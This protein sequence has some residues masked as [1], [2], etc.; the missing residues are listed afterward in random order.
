MGAT[1]SGQ[2]D[3]KCEEDEEQYPGEDEALEDSEEDKLL[4]NNGQ[5]SSQSE[6][7]ENLTDEM[8]SQ[9]EGRD[10]LD[11]GSG[12]V[13]L[14]EDPSDTTN[15]SQEDVSQSSTNNI[16]EQMNNTDDMIAKEENE[17]NNKQND[18]EI[19][20]KKI[21]RF[22]GL[23]FTLKKDK[24]EK[25]DADEPI[26]IEEDINAASPSEDSWDTI[27]VNAASKTEQNTEVIMNE[28]MGGD[29]HAESPKT[30]NKSAIG[31]ISS[32]I[33]HQEEAS[34]DKKNMEDVPKSPE[35]EELMSPIKRF[36]SQG[37]LSS[38]KKKKKEGE[39]PKEN[40]EELK[41]LDKIVEKETTKDDTT[42]T[43]L[44]VS[45][46][47]FDQDKD[48]QLYKKE[49]CKPTAVEDI[50]NSV[51][52]DKVQASP[53]KRLF[54]K[55]S[56]RRQSDTKPVD[57]N[58]PDPEKNSNENPQLSTEFIRSENEQKTMVVVTQPSGEMVDMSHEESKKKSDSTVSW[59]N[60]ICVRSGKARARKTS[61]SENETQD[62]GEVFKRT[63][64]SSIES[65]TEADHLTSSNEQGG[66]PGEDDSGSTWKSF[67]KLVTP[68]RKSR[69]EESGSV[70]QIQSDTE[71]AKDESSCSLRKLIS[72]RKKIKPDGQLEIMSS[73]EGSKETEI[74]I[75]EDDET[76]GV[77][78]LSEYEIVDPENLNVITDGQIE[79][80]KDKEMQP[81]K[82][83]DKPKQIQI[84]YN[85]GVMS[86]VPIP[87]ECMEEL[88][89]FLSKHQQLSDIPEEGIVEESVATPLSFVE[90]IT[91]DDTIDDDIV[92]MTADA[93]TAPEPASECN[94]EESTEMVSAVSQLSESPKTSGNVTPVSPVNDMR[95]SD[96]EVMESISMV[97]G[98]LSITTKDKV[99]EA[100]AVSVSQLI[101]ESTTETKVLVT[102]KKEEATSICIGI[103]SQEIRATEV[104]LPLPIVEGI[105]EIT[106]AVPTEIVSVNLVEESEAAGTAT[107]NVY[108]AEIKEIRTM[109]HDLHVEES[110]VPSET[111]SRSNQTVIMVKN[112]EEEVSPVIQMEDV[113]DNSTEFFNG[114]H[115]FAPVH[116]AVQGGSQL[117]EEQIIAL[118]IN[119]PETEGPLQSALEEP[120]YKYLTENTKTPVEAEKEHRF[121]D[122]E[123]STV[124][125]EQLTVA[126]V[127]THNVDSVPD[128][129]LNGASKI[130]ENIVQDTELAK[131][132]MYSVVASTSNTD[133]YQA[134]EIIEMTKVLAS[135]V[136]CV[137][138]TMPISE[139]TPMSDFIKTETE[140]KN[141]VQ[142]KM[143]SPL[144][145]AE[146]ELALGITLDSADALEHIGKIGDEE[147]LTTEHT[148]AETAE[149]IVDEK[150]ALNLK[151]ENL[152]EIIDKPTKERE[153][154]ERD[155]NTFVIKRTLPV[156]ISYEDNAN[157]V[158]EDMSKEHRETVLGENFKSEQTTG[159][160]ICMLTSNTAETKE[161]MKPPVISEHP[162]VYEEVAEEGIQ[163]PTT[164]NLELVSQPTL[165]KVITYA[166][167]T[168]LSPEPRKDVSAKTDTVKTHCVNNESDKLLEDEK[169]QTE[170]A[171]PEVHFEV[172]TKKETLEIVK[173]FLELRQLDT[174][175]LQTESFK[176]YEENNQAASLK[177]AETTSKVGIKHDEET[178]VDFNISDQPT[179][180]LQCLKQIDS[181]NSLEEVK[182]TDKL[183]VEKQTDNTTAK[184]NITKGIITEYKEAVE[185]Y[186]EVELQLNAEQTQKEVL[187]LKPEE[188]Q[189]TKSSHEPYKENQV[190]SSAEITATNSSVK[191]EGTE[192]ECKV[193]DQKEESGLSFKD[194][195]AV[196]VNTM[197]NVTEI[198]LK[199]KSQD[200]FV[201]Y[202][203]QGSEHVI[204]VKTA[205]HVYVG[206]GEHKVELTVGSEQDIVS[207]DVAEQEVISEIG[208]ANATVVGKDTDLIAAPN[209][210]DETTMNLSEAQA[211]VTPETVVESPLAT[212]NDPKSEMLIQSEILEVTESKA[213][214]ILISETPV[215]TCVV[216][217]W[218]YELEETQAV[219]STENQV[220]L[221]VA[222]TEIN[223]RHCYA[224]DEV[225]VDVDIRQPLHTESEFK[226]TEITK[227]VIQDIQNTANPKED[228]KRPE[229]RSGKLHEVSLSTVE[230][231]E[232]SPGPDEDVWEDAV[233][234]ISDYQS[235]STK[236]RGGLQDTV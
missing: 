39:K 205:Y 140:L 104:V 9:S 209:L 208:I 23:K 110:V 65:S 123:S 190:T 159:D 90:W 152:S 17:A 6:K 38:L 95:E 1:L 194:V 42:C 126:T 129:S 176:T 220:D 158:P 72:G 223:E 212:A 36:F 35:P 166:L 206:D 118:N 168:A 135:D 189:A 207:P 153:S 232:S 12:F 70:E 170:T 24:V 31:K 136:Q 91:Q 86:G 43:C 115:G 107:D 139:V 40:E 151:S 131:P 191:Y 48:I 117:L 58:L 67:K 122:V 20:F 82:E 79:S 210:K 85:D 236:T 233:G 10:L 128:S 8:N 47:I 229:E 145:N 16:S 112:I 2:Q 216:D 5:F 178:G 92:D 165:S 37:L 13:T 113:V 93:V 103:V 132:V 173:P 185:K 193:Y 100:P 143:Y 76:P 213:D 109:L 94:E 230:T 7:T 44:D 197:E 49:E 133:M 14:K 200:D 187:S 138:T 111:A 192:E 203:S 18:T 50:M 157:K 60:L 149:D 27:D 75:I 22:G 169:E 101:L 146:T 163:Q 141:E 55:L 199:D 61:D 177:M 164:D 11:V 218:V 83:E 155:L 215:E 147:K 154:K 148:F 62:K 66:S 134:S 80:K 78:P 69:M 184:P 102:H 81:A 105:S 222:K 87:I 183:S 150:I 231:A 51:E 73:D 41:S 161:I 29:T 4:Q 219:N 188:S 174:D 201:Q 234:D 46:S 172:L 130:I 97:S 71:I 156:A 195:D 167:T 21:F 221:S 57:I 211:G 180:L 119:R 56:T 181:V 137:E 32:H 224:H 227:Q 182:K 116:S 121:P 59:E 142:K 3:S 88:T 198:P 144:Q 214:I 196:L 225:A 127:V 26:K 228:S 96:M 160:E 125:V 120:V 98:V 175:Q 63:T 64:E 204:E 52:Q 74:I 77:V 28:R 171:K 53:F 33:E 30:Y 45:S 108:K 226:V 217:S 84:L 186:P 89:E 68:K 179:T 99:P 162:R 124:D 15:S 19:G 114:I 25:I 106:H 34:P 202:E 235:S 54:R